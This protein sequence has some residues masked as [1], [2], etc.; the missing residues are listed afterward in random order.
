MA[1][2]RMI[3]VNL[4]ENN[5]LNLKLYNDYFKRGFKHIVNNESL[6]NYIS[7]LKIVAT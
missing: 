5:T 7:C 4:T 3:K 1:N 6:P 2:I